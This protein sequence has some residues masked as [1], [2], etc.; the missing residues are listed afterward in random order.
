[1]NRAIVEMDIVRKKR[2]EGEEKAERV[3]SSCSMRMICQQH[4][5]FQCV[6]S[7]QSATWWG[8]SIA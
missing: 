1:M 5:C 4:A 3:S 7:A 2:A 6:S 8:L